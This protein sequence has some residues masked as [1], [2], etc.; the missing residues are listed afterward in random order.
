[1]NEGRKE[2][3]KKKENLFFEVGCQQIQIEEIM[4][5]EYYHVTSII[6]IIIL[7]KNYQQMPELVGESLMRN[8][9]LH[10]SKC[11]PTKYLLISKRQIVFLWCRNLSDATRTK[12]SK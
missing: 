6:V 5:F 1:M 12:S 11:L 2:G 7:S 10:I 9:C 3:R 8:S 4:E